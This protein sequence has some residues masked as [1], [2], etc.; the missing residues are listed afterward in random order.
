MKTDNF[1][2]HRLRLLFDSIQDAKNARAVEL[3]WAILPPLTP[4]QARV[5]AARIH[6]LRKLS[7][8]YI[9]YYIKDQNLSLE[10]EA[11]AMNQ[12]INEIIRGAML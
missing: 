11:H 6:F 1:I 4:A 3:A 12:N 8:Q 9:D 2:P 7:Q 10:E 5:Y